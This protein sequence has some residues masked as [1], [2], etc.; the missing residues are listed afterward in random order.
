MNRNAIIGVV[1]VLLIIA[2]VWYWTSTMPQS[3]SPS[4]TASSTQ[5]V[6]SSTTAG[7]GTGT[8]D[9]TQQSLGKVLSQGGNFT[10]T[11]ES[12]SAG[13][14][15]TG[16]VYGSAGKT[17]L[18]FTVDVNGTT[19]NTHIIR[20]GGYAYTWVDGQSTGTKVA[21]STN[22]TAPQPG[23]GGYVNVDNNTNVSSL[24]HPWSPDTTLFVPPKGISFIAR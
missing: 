15:S 13:Q 17:R 16:T 18:D 5:E 23:Q 22:T 8:T 1:V 12:I 9:G 4:E 14:H 3:G 11:V 21:I 10:C 2:G 6:A 20:S 19:V 24:C 7:S